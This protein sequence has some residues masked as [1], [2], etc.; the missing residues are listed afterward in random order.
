MQFRQPTRKELLL[1]WFALMGLTI[2]T[3]L[4]GRVTQDVTLGGL[5]MSGLLVVTGIKA[6]WILRY[7]LNLRAAPPGWNAAFIAYLVF[8]LLIILVLYLVGL[9]L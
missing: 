5:F 7:Y 8:L 9:A 1:A 6:Y 2:G 4:S 3:M